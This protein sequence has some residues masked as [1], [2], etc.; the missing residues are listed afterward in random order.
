MTHLPDQ[1][2]GEG[3]GRVERDLFAKGEGGPFAIVKE[4]GGTPVFQV[5]EPP[6]G[7]SRGL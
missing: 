2:I 7:F 3:P 5:I 1:V 6:L 4:G